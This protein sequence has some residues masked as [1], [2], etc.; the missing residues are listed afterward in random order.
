MSLSDNDHLL[1]APLLACSQVIHAAQETQVL[2][3]KAQSF[4]SSLFGLAFYL[5]V[6]L[7]IWLLKFLTSPRLKRNHCLH[8]PQLP[9]ALISVM[10]QTAGLLAFFLLSFFTVDFH[11][12]E[13][14]KM[15]PLIASKTPPSL[16]PLHLSL[17]SPPLTS[18]PCTRL[19]SPSPCERHG[20]TA[21][22]VRSSSSSVACKASL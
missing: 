20:E 18:P 1:S 3:L 11:S 15:L 4:L 21:A 14:Q 13:T 12:K 17:T 10:S 8:S 16:S 19:H 2:A 22:N 6:P 5:L 9:A 7:P